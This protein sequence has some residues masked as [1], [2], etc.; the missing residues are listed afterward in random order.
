MHP[1]GKPSYEELEREREAFRQERD[2][3][4][5]LLELATRGDLRPLLEEALALIVEVTGATKGYLALYSDESEAPG[6]AI[7]KSCTAEELATIQQKISQGI[8]AEAMSTGQTIHIA[9]A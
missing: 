1:P 7:A 8:I 4:W 5:R 6:F 3:Y 2:L 9:S